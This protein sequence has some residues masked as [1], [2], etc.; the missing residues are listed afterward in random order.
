[1]DV[2]VIKDNSGI[3]AVLKTKFDAETW[4]RQHYRNREVHQF[5][6]HTEGLTVKGVDVEAVR[7]P[8]HEVHT[9]TGETGYNVRPGAT[10]GTR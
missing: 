6:N 2:W 10:H 4:L 7:H 3:R 5:G 9:V 1:M 8:V